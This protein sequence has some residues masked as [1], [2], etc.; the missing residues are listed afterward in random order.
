M[1]RL[2]QENIWRSTD[3]EKVTRRSREGRL[4]ARIPYEREECCC[5]D[6][7]CTDF[8]DRMAEWGIPLDEIVVEEYVIDLG[9]VRERTKKGLRT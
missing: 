6:S 2:E 1:L 8:E 7:R 5:G 9:G 3:P 4:V